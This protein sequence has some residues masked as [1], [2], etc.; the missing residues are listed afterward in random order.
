[1]KICCAGKT[2]WPELK[3]NLSFTQMCRLKFIFLKLLQN[4]NC[5]IQLKG[6]QKNE[7]AYPEYYLRNCSCGITVYI[8]MDTFVISRVYSSVPSNKG[9]A[10][11]SVVS[12]TESA[13]A[14]TDNSYSD[15]NISIAVT[16]QRINNPTTNGKSIKER[17]VSDIVYIGY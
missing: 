15:G 8:L 3:M 13:A 5:K 4:L 16:E 1:M 7:K 6:R 14:T 12:K 2:Y 17:S 9:T 11:K 10:D